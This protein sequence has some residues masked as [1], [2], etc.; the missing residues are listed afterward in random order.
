MAINFPANPSTDDEFLSNGVT[1]VYDGTK[2]KVISKPTD[3][4]PFGG[5]NNDIFYENSLVATNDYT[6]S[7][8]KSAISAGPITIDAGVTITIPDGSRWVVV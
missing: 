7:T 8:A 2:W 4:P 1:Y 3:I 6:V 5:G